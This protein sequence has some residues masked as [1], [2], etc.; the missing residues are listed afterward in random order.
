MGSAL[1][2]DA[3]TIIDLMPGNKPAGRLDHICFT[4]TPTDLAAIEVSGTLT[5]DEAP[6]ERYGAQGNGTSIY[7]RD[8]DRTTI[9][10]RRYS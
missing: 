3:T 10:L 9:E 2:V 6:S 8:P 7:T 5:I 1:R 4:I